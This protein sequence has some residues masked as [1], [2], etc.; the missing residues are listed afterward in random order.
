M[1]PKL[2]ATPNR[3]PATT[4]VKPQQTVKLSPS[5][6]HKFP[7]TLGQLSGNGGLPSD[8]VNGFGGFDPI[9][10]VANGVV[11]HTPSD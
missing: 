5:P 7:A 4:P 6:A 10:G 2:A 3:T 11:P 9:T 1:A 8:S